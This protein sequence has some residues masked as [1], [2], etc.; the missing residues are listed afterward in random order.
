MVL[1]GASKICAMTT[2]KAALR[3]FLAFPGSDEK[4]PVGGGGG[5]GRVL[6]AGWTSSS[7]LD[8][9][10]SSRL[11]PAEGTLLLQP[12]GC[13]SRFLG[14]PAILGR[15]SWQPQLVLDVQSGETRPPP[16]KKVV[17]TR[18][19]VAKPLISFLLFSVPLKIVDLVRAQDAGGQ[20]GEV[21]QEDTFQGEPLHHYWLSLLPSLFSLHPE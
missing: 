12:P 15:G 10:S 1:E 7:R 21:F 4:A 17:D 5:G 13:S 11:P 2:Q 20:H 18:I 16:G 8:R 19:V 6:E 3:A 9:S 14:V